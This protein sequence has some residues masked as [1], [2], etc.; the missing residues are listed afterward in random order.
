MQRTKLFPVL[1]AVLLVAQSVR[2]GQAEGTDGNGGGGRVEYGV[3]AIT[4]GQWNMTNGHGAWAN[5]LDLGMGVTLWR[6]VRAEAAAMATCLKGNDTGAVMQDFSNINAACRPF[7]LI[8]F[9][10]VQKL[11]GDRM[12]LFLGVKQADEDYFNSP[13]AGIFTGASYGCLPVVNDNYEANV[14]PL[15]ALG[16]HAELAATDRLI[17]RTSL[18]NGRSYDTVDRIF[19]FRPHADGV[20]NLGSVT[21]SN[22]GSEGED[23]EMLPATYTAGWNVGNEAAEGNGR[24]TQGGFW[25]TAEQ[26]LPEIG[27]VQPAVGA[28]YA[29]QFHGTGEARE[30][31][32]VALS[33]GRLTRRGGTL[34]MGVSR[35]YY[36]SVHETDV[37][38]TFK[39]PLSGSFSLQPAFHFFRT[40]GK[41]QVVGLLRV[42]F[43]M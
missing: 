1:A 14:F 4:E 27:R 12:S 11:A 38:T 31:W 6:G 8:R 2:A 21:Y 35:A 24:C 13:Q 23:D 19:R 17:V 20:M 43:E 18:Y 37:E 10:L 7:R 16:F 34:A 25:L 33:L 32:N 15:S 5:R 3:S 40:S 26:P 39:M 28:T 22:G 42:A 41:S 9:G 29:R 36:G 30:Y